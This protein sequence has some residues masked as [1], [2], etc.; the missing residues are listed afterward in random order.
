MIFKKK[1]GSLHRPSVHAAEFGHP[2]KHTKNA[3]YYERTSFPEAIDTTTETQ[4]ARELF[5]G[6][7]AT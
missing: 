5:L 1:K 3:E 4:G 2:D 6:A 7:A